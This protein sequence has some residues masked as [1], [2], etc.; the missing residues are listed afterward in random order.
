M[1]RLPYRR[2]IRRQTCDSLAQLTPM[3]GSSNS[4]SPAGRDIQKPHAE[5]LFA[6]ACAESTGRRVDDGLQAVLGQ[7]GLGIHRDLAG[8]VQ[9]AAIAE[10]HARGR[11]PRAQAVRL[12]EPLTNRQHLRPGAGC[13]GLRAGQAAMPPSTSTRNPPNWQRGFQ[14]LI[15]GFRPNGDILGQTATDVFRV[16]PIG[17]RPQASPVDPRRHP[18]TGSIHTK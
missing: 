15:D 17:F 14:Q 6:N 13:A 12:P 1:T 10:E 9:R 5:Q 7:I 4:D 8:F 2:P 11:A 18:P 3:A 16:R